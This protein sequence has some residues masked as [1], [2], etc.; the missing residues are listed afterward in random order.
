MAKE[1]DGVYPKDKLRKKVYN[2]FYDTDEGS[3]NLSWL[4]ATLQVVAVSN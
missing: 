3:K 1:F 2:V 4:V